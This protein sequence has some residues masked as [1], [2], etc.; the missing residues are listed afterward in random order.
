MDSSLR[1]AS[2]AAALQVT[3]TGAAAAIPTRAAVDDFLASHFP[4]S[5]G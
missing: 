1:L 4:V 2:A 5:K 3:K